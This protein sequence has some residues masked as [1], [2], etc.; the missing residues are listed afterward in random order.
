MMDLWLVAIGA[1]FLGYGLVSKR[2][3]TTPV[4]GP[5]IFVG[6]GFILGSTVL[7]VLDAE[8]SELGI[9]VLLEATLAIVLFSD[10]AVINASNW[11]REAYVPA[12]L[13]LIGL[14]LTVVLG[15]L[16]ALVLF[17]DLSVWE[18]GLVA[19]ILAPTDAALGQAV[20]SNRRVP[21]VIRQGLATESGLN[22]GIALLFVVIFLGGAEEALGGGS[23]GTL[24]SFLGNEVLLAGAVGML[25]GVLG[26]WL[27]LA[28]TDR[29]WMSQSWLQIAVVAIGVCAY[30]LA[31][32][33]GGSGFIAAWLAGLLFGR[34]VRGQLD[35]ANRFA[36]ALGSALTMTS[37]LAFGAVLLPPALELLTWR[38]IVYAVLSLTLFRMVP[39]AAAL[40]G[41][42]LRAVS[43][44]FIGWFGPRGLASIV[45]AGVVVE[46][47]GLPNVDL[48]VSIAMTTVGL[49]VIAHG[50]TSWWGSESYGEWAAVN[51]KVALDQAGDTDV[52]AVPRRFQS[53]GTAQ[54]ATVAP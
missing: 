14:P 31:I 9:S 28:A 40:A 49:S 44:A 48:I 27:L 23:I 32:L 17:A 7:D 10:A 21:Q 47:S 22:D 11:R 13:L 52:G 41:A 45:L 36:E 51:E 30:G 8:S 46:S 25:V 35:E 26:G 53:P 3:G 15:L 54:D 19:A 5:M 29:D 37:L 38:S 34:T 50:A 24:L 43:V 2:L 6:V 39:V 16:G 18:A 4:T 1:L 20:V 42:K 12:R 33:L